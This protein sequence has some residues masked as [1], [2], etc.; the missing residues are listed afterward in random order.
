[1]DEE[2]KKL[3]EEL[4]FSGIKKPTFGKMLYF[5]MLDASQIF[6]YPQIGAEEKERTEQFLAK[7][8]TFI[9]KEVDPVA[10]DR[11]ASIPENVTKGLADLGVMGMTVP[12]EYGG[13]GMT[14]YAYCKL[15]ELIAGRCASTA[16]YVNVHQSIG[17]KALILF[18]NEQQRAFWLPKLAKAEKIAA[19]S[20][21]EPNA[22]SDASGVETRAVY[23]AAKKVYRI[24]GRKQWTTNGSIAGLLTVMAKTEIDTPS[25][26]Q[27]KVTAFLVSPD[28]PGFRIANPALEKVGMRGTKTANLEF[29]DLEV[30]EA[31][32]LGPLGTGLRVCLTLL[33]Y[34]RT[35]FGATCTG[36]AKVLVEKAIS[37]AT[38]RRQFNRPLASFGLVKKKIAKMAALAYAMDATTYL[39]AGLIDNDVEDIMLESAML[40]VFASEA[41]WGIIYDTM[42]IYGGRSFFTDQPFERMMRDARLN[43]IG[44]G[45]NEVM[46][47]F[48]GVVG[49]RDVGMQLKGVWDALQNPFKD[50]AVLSAFAKQRFRALQTQKIPVK[51]SEI[52]EEAK[53]IAK[54]IRNF[55]F[56]VTKLLARYREEIV[57]KQ[58]LLDRISSSAMA[59]YSAIAVLSK[60]DSRLQDHQADKNELETAKLYCKMAVS[61]IERKLKD[62]FENNDDAYEELSDH[63]TGLAKS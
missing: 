46:R 16:L 35:T 56:C 18:G 34:G 43:M 9:E 6:P 54:A 47:A 44:E 52:A 23:D 27:D 49:M 63:L 60:I 17:L 10:I 42:Q 22:G 3:V 32:V 50:Y 1:M 36:V 30:P 15:S 62:L 39:T 57:E 31:N 40:K 21:T 2:Q 58:L 25:G 28:M 4:L 13:L 51:S 7:V 38:T 61:K 5:G 26:K 20:L 53:L 33:D 24:N 41:L 11:N 48:I 45:A 55:G 14:Q 19:F 12:K 59:I 8:K 37:H 29:H